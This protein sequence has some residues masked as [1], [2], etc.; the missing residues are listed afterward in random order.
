MRRMPGSTGLRGVTIG[1]SSIHH[2]VLLAASAILLGSAA[3]AARPL[4]PEPAAAALYRDLERLV[5]VRAATGWQIDRIE[6]EGLL[7]DS[8]MSTCQVQP[9]QRVLLRDWL[10]ARITALGG[11]VE[12]AYQA[13]GRDLDRVSELLALTRVRMALARTLDAAGADC[14]FWL[15]PRPVFRGRQFSDDR[16]QISLGGGGTGMVASRGDD[17]DMQFGG[18]GRLLFG[19]NFGSHLA[20]YTGVAVGGSASFPKNES[21]ERSNLVLTIDTAVPAVVRYRMINTYVEAAAGYQARASEADWGD[22]EHGMQMGVAFGGRATRVRWFF[23]G[24]AI[25]LS[26]ERTFPGDAPALH[27]VKMGFRAVADFDL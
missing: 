18:A 13:H 25:D 22:I 19:R 21:G 8:L 23:P 12:R 7:A 1:A 15:E 6:I 27:V 16:W 26:Y 24:A 3:C 20:L 5:S 10:D 2:L 9:A 17:R 11:P 14:P 4:P